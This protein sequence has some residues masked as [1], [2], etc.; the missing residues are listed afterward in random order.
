MKPSDYIKKG[1]CRKNLAIDADGRAVLT[2][3]LSAVAWCL[4]GAV[5]AASKFDYKTMKRWFG[6][7]E[8][9]MDEAIPKWNDRRGRTKEQVI[10]LLKSVNL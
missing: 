4:S 10:A 9:K 5:C 2:S 7:I 1:W 3:D 8:S 6:L